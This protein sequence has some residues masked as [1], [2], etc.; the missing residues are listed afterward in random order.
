MVPLA[1]VLV[2]ICGL[3][4]L[5]CAGAGFGKELMAGIGALMVIYSAV[6]LVLWRPVFRRS[7]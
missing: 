4:L 6:V 1:F 5:L 7:G 3:I 2:L